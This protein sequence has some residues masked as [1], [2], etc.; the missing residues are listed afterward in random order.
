MKNNE[1]PSKGAYYA[2][3][4]EK[5]NE[6]YKN[7]EAHNR[8]IEIIEKCFSAIF[9]YNQE[10]QGG[11]GLIEFKNKYEKAPIYLI[12]TASHV[13]VECA[14]VCE[15][16][17]EEYCI[18]IP[19]SDSV[20]KDGNG[21]FSSLYILP[22]KNNISINKN[23]D[24]ALIQLTAG[25]EELKERYFT[26]TY[27]DKFLHKIDQEVLICSI[28][29]NRV[30]RATRK[31]FKSETCNGIIVNTFQL[32]TKIVGID[33]DFF[34]IAYPNQIYTMN[35][36]CNFKPLEGKSPDP[37]GFS[38][39]IVWDYSGN[40]VKPLGIV[41]ELKNGNIR[42]LSFNTIIDFLNNELANNVT[43]K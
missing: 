30:R 14:S 13:V 22:L 32:P 25:I 23:L 19:I 3:L 17:K 38:G 8:H 42:C 15:N 40:T 1:S 5:G 10:F 27:E 7:Y 4:D 2:S 11:G 26:I 39:S 28:P 37:H 33:G 24:L 43:K 29:A 18:K 6:N 31:V 12:V 36:K 35:E 20:K 9:D 21:E 41:I 34:D 16:L